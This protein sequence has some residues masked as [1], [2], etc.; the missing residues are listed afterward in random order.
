[1]NTDLLDCVNSL[2]E[3]RDLCGDERE[4]MADWE[5]ENRPLSRYERQVIR[6]EVSRTWNQARSE[7][8]VTRPIC[9]LE[10]EKINRDLR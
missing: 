6:D 3:V 1:M 5:A 9:D 8:G 2:V 7:A 4:A 10:R